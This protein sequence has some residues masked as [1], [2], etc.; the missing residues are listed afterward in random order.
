MAT[1][2]IRSVDMLILRVFEVERDSTHKEGEPYDRGFFGQPGSR[3]EQEAEGLRWHYKIPLVTNPVVL[4]EFAIPIGAGAL[5][6]AIIILLVSGGD[7]LAA[8]LW[9]LGFFALFFGLGFIILLILDLIG[10]KASFYIGKDSVGYVVGSSLRKFN[11][12]VL[13]LSLLGRSPTVVGASLIG[14][15]RESEFISWDEVRSITVYDKYRVIY[16]R[17]KSYIKPIVLFCSRENFDDVVA[18][19]KKYAQGVK[20]SVK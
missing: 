15:G 5:A 7:F 2:L 8:A 10:I 9:S 3:S 16:F 20:I 12:L 13:L 4:R 11:R 17:R 1:V 18:L 6:M 14:I 19:V